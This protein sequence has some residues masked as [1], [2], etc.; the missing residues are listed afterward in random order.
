[1]K[2][3]AHPI[4]LA[5]I[6]AIGLI[7]ILFFEWHTDE[8][9]VVLPILLLT[10]FVAGLAAPRHFLITGTIFGWCILAAHALSNATGL[11]IPRYQHG[12]PTG[13]DWAAMALLVLPSVAASFAGARSRTIAQGAAT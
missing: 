1:M 13:G 8:P 3:N 12:P 6:L 10:C 2:T 9:L 4:R 11:L 5:G 7:V